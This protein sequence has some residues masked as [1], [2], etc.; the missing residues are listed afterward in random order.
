M[1]QSHLFLFACRSTH[2]TYQTNLTS[3]IQSNRQTREPQRAL[4]MVEFGSPSVQGTALQPS[5][6]EV[7]HLVL[8]STTT[9]TTTSP[10]AMDW[11]SQQLTPASPEPHRHQL[12]QNQTSNYTHNYKHSPTRSTTNPSPFLALTTATSCQTSPP[13]SYATCSLLLRSSEP[14]RQ[15]TTLATPQQHPSSDVFL[16]TTTPHKHDL[17]D[18]DTLGPLQQDGDAQHIGAIHTFRTTTDYTIRNTNS[19]SRTSHHPMVSPS[20]HHP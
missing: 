6:T 5:P 2:R 9:S 13:Y 14:L 8:H 19:K 3:Q 10:T 16:T 18:I 1:D 7:P 17:T 11:R 15:R 12:S 4:P 20:T